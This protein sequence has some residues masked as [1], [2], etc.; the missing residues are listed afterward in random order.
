MKTKRKPGFR[1]M[2]CIAILS[3]IV[4][5]AENQAVTKSDQLSNVS[6]TS[7]A[8]REPQSA[9][10]ILNRMAEFLANTPRFTV[11]LTDSYDVLQESGQMI[12]FS[13]SRV[14]TVNRPNELRVEVEQSDGEKHLILY[15]GKEITAFSPSLNV[16]SQAEIY[17]GIDEAVKYFLRDLHMRLP[18]AAL[19]LNR[20]PEEVERRTMVVEYVEQTQIYGVLAH[21]LAGRTKTVDYQVWIAAGSK[22]LPLRIVL[23]Y[24]NAKGNPAFRAHFSDWNLNP[25]FD[26]SLFTF[27]PPEGAKKIAFLAE[28]PQAV[29]VGPDETEKQE[30]GNEN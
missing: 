3:A 14:L 20:F 2:V 30:A 18:L 6:P 17:G 8:I 12:E 19:L 26:E 16:Y 9:E 11:N 28:L 15:D 5:C 1:R 21:H 27:V 24:K 13:E 4:G 25:A 10:D 22:P 29:F 7:P 23:T